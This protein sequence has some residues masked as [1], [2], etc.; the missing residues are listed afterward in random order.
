MPR[1]RSSR[2]SP[3]ATEEVVRGSDRFKRTGKKA[4]VGNKRVR[5]AG[6]PH[7]QDNSSAS[8]SEAESL[9]ES[10][11]KRRRRDDRGELPV[12]QVERLSLAPFAHPGP[13]SSVKQEPLNDE[14]PSL[15]DLPTRKLRS[16][17]VSRSRQVRTPR[18]RR[19]EAPTTTV[20][21]EQAPTPPIDSID[22]QI[23]NIMHFKLEHSGIPIKTELPT[24][25]MES[26]SA[27][28]VDDQGEEQQESRATDLNVKL[29][30]K[31]EIKSESPERVLDLR[32]EGNG[33]NESDSDHEAEEDEDEEP[34]PEPV[35]PGSDY[36]FDFG[37]FAGENLF[38]RG[39][40]ADC[41]GLNKEAYIEWMLEVH[42]PFQPRYDDLAEGLGYYHRQALLS[43]E[44]D[45]PD[46]SSYRWEWG[47]FRGR[48]LKKTPEWYVE[49]KR[50]W[51]DTKPH[52][53]HRLREA[54]V[55]RGLQTKANRWM[56]DATFNGRRWIPNRLGPF[57]YPTTRAVERIPSE[58]EYP[59]ACPTCRWRFRRVDRSSRP[60]R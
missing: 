9:N 20:K 10:P 36:I 59:C 15:H 14:N 5:S 37:K 31:E 13:S 57:L 35:E 48:R 45:H 11:I 58:A 51:V 19:G 32:S 49:S 39:S 47:R 30:V 44:A 26:A 23:D 60:L 18:S 29:E 50:A 25:P 42:I 46:A 16:R 8:E 17:S 41:Y 53:Y 22:Y 38:S 34:E 28:S 33:D 54:L 24:D 55:W 27:L 21:C 3:G 4:T 40:A 52:G 12:D 6:L 43:Y 2:P 1:L 7:D 56:L